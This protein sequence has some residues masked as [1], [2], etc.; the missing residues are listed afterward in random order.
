MKLGDNVPSYLQK[1]KHLKSSKEKNSNPRSPWL[2][3]QLQENSATSAAEAWKQN[4]KRSQEQL[5][6]CCC[7]LLWLSLST[8]AFGLHSTLD[9]PSLCL[10]CF[11]N[12]AL[13]SP[14]PLSHHGLR[15]V[16][17]FSSKGAMLQLQQLRAR[18]KLPCFSFLFYHYGGPCCP[19][20]MITQ[21][22]S[23]YAK[24]PSCSWLSAKLVIL[25]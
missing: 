12:I 13:L 2:I 16:L 19:R 3:I 9:L 6:E 4:W 1:K 14:L 18:R 5:K 20:G 15:A 7:R 21:Q 25:F 17:L 24:R 8:P 10:W 23:S 11:Q 22:S